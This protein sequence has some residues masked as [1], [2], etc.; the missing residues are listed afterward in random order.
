M[1]RLAMLLSLL[2]AACGADPGG[3]TFQGYVEGDFIAVAP[4]VGGRIA[5]LAVRRGSVVESGALL[6]RLDD[7]EA[8]AAVEEAEAELARAKAQLMNLRQGQRPPEIA[9]IEAQ[10]AE[11]QAALDKARRDFERQKVLF[12]RRVIAESQLDEAREAITVAEARL[13]A[14]QRQKDVAE[15]PARTPEIEA[16]ERAVQAAEAALAQASSRLAKHV[17]KATAAGRI[18]DI[19][20]EAGEVASAGAAVLSLLPDGRRKVVFFVPEASRAGLTIGSAVGVSCDGCPAGI[21]AELTFLGTEAEFTPPVIF[22]RETRDK[23][24][25]RAEAYLAADVALPL[26]QPVDVAATPTASP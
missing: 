15:L 20:Y 22:S 1:K 4:E 18:E 9:V 14:S 13:A 5:E 12:E 7:A 2:L 11:A 26:G 23:L 21:R 6:F 8:A 24:V 25:F 19:Y 3:A 16:G 17:V 10:I